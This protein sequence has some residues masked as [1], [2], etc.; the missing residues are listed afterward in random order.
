L[1]VLLVIIVGYAGLAFVLLALRKRDNDPKIRG[2]LDRKRETMDRSNGKSKVDPKG[3]PT[4]E[5][6]AIK[7][8]AVITL[9]VSAITVVAFLVTSLDTI[10]ETNVGAAWAIVIFLTLVFFVGTTVIVMLLIR[11][12]QGVGE[13]RM[14]N[15]SQAQRPTHSKNLNDMTPEER[16]R[17]LAGGIIVGA[18]LSSL[19]N[20][21]N[22]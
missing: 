16:M 9:V 10:G 6:G 17:N 8:L 20:K 22:K 11:W 3:P 21:H 2:R 4:V 15:L 12:A 13:Q 5:L 14:A 18:G 1:G 19:L 7:A